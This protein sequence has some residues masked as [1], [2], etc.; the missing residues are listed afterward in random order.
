M[1]LL[2]NLK[3]ISLFLLSTVTLN[4]CNN[5]TAEQKHSNKNEAVSTVNSTT[6]KTS[7]SSEASPIQADLDKAKAEGK[8]VF[9]VVKDGKSV[10]TDK[11]IAVAEKATAI[12]ENAIVLEMNR[13]DAANQQLVTQWRLSGAPLPLTLVISSKGFPTG[14]YTFAQ[15]TPENLAA[16]V[17]SPK[18]EMVYDAIDKNKHVIIAF[19]KNTFSDRKQVS[20]VC[21]KAIADLNNEAVFIEVDMENEKEASFMQQT[22]VDPSTA[23]GS[24]T[25]VINKQGQ[26]VHTSTE[27]PEASQLVKAA[28]T[29]V[30]SG[31]GPGGC[32]SGG[33]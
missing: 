6:E 15:A 31:C 30:R 19:S 18:L 33:C 10:D 17:P 2:N 12:Y 16:A 4:A 14:G 20:E 23:T 7:S 11:A 24:I 21:K 3:L 25:L 22:Q 29:P 26:V 1:K 8:A 32:G 28:N 5:A 27:I 9:I 13:D